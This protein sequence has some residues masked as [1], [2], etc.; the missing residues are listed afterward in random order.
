[1]KTPLWDKYLSNENFKKIKDFENMNLS[2][3]RVDN[4][5]EV[6]FK[7]TYSPNMY[8]YEQDGLY[9]MCVNH[10]TLIDAGFPE[11][12]LKREREFFK[13][14]YLYEDHYEFD[15]VKKDRLYHYK[16]GEG[17]FLRLIRVW[18]KRYTEII[19]NIDPQDIRIEMSA[20]LDTRILSYFWRYNPYNYTVYTKPG[21]DE[22]ELAKKTIQFVNDNFPCNLNVITDKKGVPCKYELNGGSIIHG[23][24]IPTTRND[25]KDII[26][27]SKACNKAKHIV[28]D[29]CP[30]YDKDILKL[31]G[32]YPGQVKL[33][34]YY[35]LCKDKD[36]YRQPVMSFTRSPYI[37]DDNLTEF[38][39]VNRIFSKDLKITP[40][41]FVEK[42]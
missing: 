19:R 1:M 36:L 23:Y 33:L 29:I 5:I 26:G 21:K 9:Y 38:I 8:I 25:F 16:K 40:E 27:N 10:Q 37:F 15:W 39:R 31:R 13:T 30:F 41:Y 42:Q 11:D 12:K 28:K 24:F 17:N 6:K 4:H 14:L 34:L 3:K 35:L 2:I 32:D 20:G 7:L 18:A 22:T